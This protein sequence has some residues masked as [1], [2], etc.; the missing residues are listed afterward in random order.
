MDSI[1]DLD[2]FNEAKIL[3]KRFAEHTSAVVSDS[4]VNSRFED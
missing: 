2:N 3:K 1:R 4:I